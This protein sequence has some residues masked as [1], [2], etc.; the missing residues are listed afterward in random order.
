[1]AG[2]CF[3]HAGTA[4]A[5]FGAAAV[6]GKMPCRDVIPIA[7]NEDRAA[8][9]TVGSLPRRIVNVA[10]IDVMQPCIRCDPSRFAQ[11]VRWCRR[12]VG[13]L[14]IRMKGREVE[15]HVGPESIA[16]CPFC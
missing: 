14:P 13:Q 15:R 10:G 12:S 3:E 5:A 6:S 2:I 16:L 8:S 7:G 11:R 9:V 1:M 4:R